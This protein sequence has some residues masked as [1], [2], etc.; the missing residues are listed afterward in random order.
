MKKLYRK[1]SVI[2]ILTL[3]FTSLGET[4][5]LMTAKAAE[6]GY[7]VT[8]QYIDG[9]EVS[10]SV[11]PGGNITSVP[12]LTAET[13]NKR[14][15]WEYGG[16]KYTEADIP[17][18]TINKNCIFK[19][20]YITIEKHKVSFNYKDS[21]I[22]TEEV[23][24]GKSLG[25]KFPSAPANGPAKE[26]AYF[27]GW[28]S[29][30]TSTVS[31]VTY[32]A[33]LKNY[34]PILKD[35]TVEA[36]YTYS[37]HFHTTSGNI[38][39]HTMEYGKPFTYTILP[40]ENYENLP[41]SGDNTGASLGKAK[42]F[43][44]WYDSESG[45]NSYSGADG[46]FTDQTFN[47][48]STELFPHWDSPEVGN[49]SVTFQV[50]GLSGATEDIVF[51]NVAEDAVI[52]SFPKVTKAGHTLT[53]WVDASD[54]TS[55]YLS[56]NENGSNA[57]KIKKTVTLK[58]IFE[59][60]KHEV[61]FNYRTR[62]TDIPDSEI[63]STD[64]NTVYKEDV[65]TIKNIPYGSLI[66]KDNIPNNMAQ[67]MEMKFLAPTKEGS[68][69]L[70]EYTAV[71]TYNG[72]WKTGNTEW[73]FDTNTVSNDMKK[74]TGGDSSLHPCYD[75]SYQP[76]NPPKDYQYDE[77]SIFDTKTCKVIFSYL[78]TS[79][80]SDTEECKVKYGRTIPENAYP[81]SKVLPTKVS[82]FYDK[83]SK[84]S[85]DYI[86]FTA[87]YT[88]TGKWLKSGTGVVWEHDRFVT[89]DILTLVPLYS[90]K[91]DPFVP[92]SDA[93]WDGTSEDVGDSIDKIESKYSEV[94]FDHNNGSGKTTKIKVPKNQP[95][96]KKIAPKVTKAGVKFVYWATDKEGKQPYDWETP[97]VSENLT[98]YAIW[99]EQ[100]DIVFN[101]EGG[102]Y[103]SVE[104]IT[105]GEKVPK[106]TEDPVKKNYIFLGWSKT[107]QKN[108][109]SI[110]YEKYAYDFDTLVTKA[111]LS[112]GQM[113]LYAW[114]K[115]DT[116]VRF[117][118][119]TSATDDTYKEVSLEIGKDGSFIFPEYVPEAENSPKNMI[120]EGWFTKRD[121]G[122]QLTSQSFNPDH[123]SKS[124]YYAHW[125]DGFK[126][127]YVIDIEDN[128]R[129]TVSYK[130]GEKPEPIPVAQRDGASITGWYLDME[131]TQLADIPSISKDTTVY[132]KWEKITIGSQANIFLDANGGTFGGGSTTKTVTDFTVG[133]KVNEAGLET[134]TGPEGE[135][136]VF[137]GWC[138]SKDSGKTI[139]FSN[140][141]LEGSV[142]FYAKWG[143]E[144]RFE[145]N[146]SVINKGIPNQYIGKG[147][148]I[149][150]P[151]ELVHKDYVLI[152]WSEKQKPDVKSDLWDFD[153]DV[154]TKQTTLY[155]IW[156]V[157]I[158][159]DGNGGYFIDPEWGKVKTKEVEITASNYVDELSV[160]P[161]YPSRAFT[162]WYK[163]P[164]GKEKFEFLGSN[165]P[166][167]VTSSVRVYAGWTDEN[168]E[169]KITVDGGKASHSLSLAGKWVA[170]IAHVPEGKLFVRW[171]GEGVDFNDRTKQITTFLMPTQD[172]TVNA[173]F[174]DDPS[175]VPKP[176]PTPDNNNS[177][178]NSSNNNSSNTSTNTTAKHTKVIPVD[179][180]KKSGKVTVT[181]DDSK[182]QSA[183]EA[184]LLEKALEEA[185]NV[186]NPQASVILKISKNDKISQVTVNLTN[187]ALAQLI[188][189]NIDVVE[190]QDSLAVLKLDNKTLKEIDKKTNGNVSLVVG[191][192]TQ[193]LSKSAK[194]AVGS[195]PVIQVS[196]QHK[197]IVDGKQKTVKL[198]K[199]SS[200]KIEVRLP[201]SPTKAEKKLGTK[202]MYGVYIKSNGKAYYVKN[203]KYDTKKEELVF[204]INQ[205]GSYSITY[206]K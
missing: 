200:G 149:V 98:L 81:N 138:L 129:K 102:S 204:K 127:I 37:L 158:V 115:S 12:T 90:V 172:V 114:Y 93:V 59:V 122:N 58:P 6:E 176:T 56:K 128:E 153:K 18:L 162:G 134:P 186:K 28:V 10:Q 179:L 26:Q 7:T 95:L 75:I 206:K 27:A 175:I 113:K 44:G 195:R 193:K 67:K 86:E 49:Y 11:A 123:G 78:N 99:A 201:Y 33:A 55:I 107:R 48:A 190:I 94:T 71:Y 154:V 188:N 126:I 171:E 19:E 8:F 53:K 66:P 132:A 77:D 203:R 147:K 100:G 50:A 83:V 106:P 82:T 35:W 14:Y 125:K 168:I 52:L 133:N 130:V 205:L 73:D 194:K 63:N 150:E 96:D 89:E 116:R 84:D 69:E 196:I 23:E 181:I 174:I 165:N 104:T 112:A 110:D 80:T 40:G 185:K 105:L 17:K 60:N 169:Y 108:R 79:G 145:P 159:F 54:E 151:E 1:I 184:A 31:G 88:F 143:Y 57:T 21:S 121:G 25:S 29:G 155:A 148:K 45:G 9:K 61:Q 156:G 140:Y 16:K 68:E 87:T 46:V 182:I 47:K 22:K 30:I 38:R 135:N 42:T 36:L 131:L 152:G 161:T 92:D 34:T 15:F 178:N 166:T 136:M 173:V 62:N 74:T 13:S 64:L 111:D 192:S 183:I 20:V 85:E 5:R 41:S 137:V 197:K 170:V 189:T 76:H 141:Y 119:N 177:N 142:T 146:N 72:K 199:L 65:T 51:D 24:H 97:T 163:D 187:K 157:S 117:Y 103:I 191:T 101:S 202:K 180:S 167:I 139:D 39:T 4:G 43:L 109:P 32:T 3:L 91:F 2:L 144:I 198:T 124:N 118:Y 164:F 120:F 70:T 160:Q